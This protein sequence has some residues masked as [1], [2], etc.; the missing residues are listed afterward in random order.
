M[1]RCQRHK[2]HSQIEIGTWGAPRHLLS[3]LVCYICILII[4]CKVHQLIGISQRQYESCHT[5]NCCHKSCKIR[6]YLWVG[7]IS[8]IFNITCLRKRGEKNAC[9]ISGISH[10][11]FS[12]S[13]SDMSS[14]GYIWTHNIS[15]LA[16]LHLLNETYLPEKMDQPIICLFDI[17]T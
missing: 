15:T 8:R 13:C 3:R 5:L 7:K 10:Q 16:P 6:K 2:S 11:T 14:K 4:L 1:H 12:V 17:S 9:T